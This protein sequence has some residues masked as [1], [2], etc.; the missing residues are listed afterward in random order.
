MYKKKKIFWPKFLFFTVYEKK[1]FVT[2]MI[3][4]KI[5][6]FISILKL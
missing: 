5:K 4:N 2:I 3:I 1:L 6:H